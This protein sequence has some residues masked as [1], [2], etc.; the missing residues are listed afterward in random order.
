M[1]KFE[2]LERLI[3]LFREPLN[4]PNTLKSIPF[5]P[6]IP[7][8]VL[9][10]REQF[11][12]SPWRLGEREKIFHLIPIPSISHFVHFDHSPTTNG[13]SNYFETIVELTKR[14]CKGSVRDVTHFFFP[15]FPQQY[16]LLNR[17]ACTVSTTTVNSRAI[18]H[19]EIGAFPSG[20]FE[21]IDQPFPFCRSNF[22]PNFAPVKK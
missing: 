16:T 2:S 14:D 1:R 21:G 19:A 8:I 10:L 9:I 12:T 7:N 11:S 15:F 17:V 20:P 3:F 13:R 4:S 18:H 6:K 5:Q 22:S